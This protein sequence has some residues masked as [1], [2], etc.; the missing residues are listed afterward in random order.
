MTK[1]SDELIDP[2]KRIRSAITLMVQSRLEAQKALAELKDNA[3]TAR[4]DY[5]NAIEELENA[6][7]AIYGIEVSLGEAHQFTLVS[8]ATEGI[9]L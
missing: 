6:V 1:E 7:D 2:A 4:I 8:Y 5:E 3:E 9:L